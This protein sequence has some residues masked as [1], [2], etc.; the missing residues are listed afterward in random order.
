MRARTWR[1][2]EGPPDRGRASKARLGRM[3]SRYPTHEI[4][5]FSFQRNLRWANPFSATLGTCPELK[6]HESIAF[7]S[8]IHSILCAGLDSQGSFMARDPLIIESETVKEGKPPSSEDWPA[9]LSSGRPQL[10]AAWRQIHLPAQGELTS[11]LETPLWSF[12]Q[13]APPWS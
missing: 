6:R 10:L 12:E 2:V 13:R 1:A 3:V 4:F 11:S 9:S 8:R 7:R 5:S